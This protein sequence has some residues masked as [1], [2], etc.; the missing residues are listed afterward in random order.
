MLS[1]SSKLLLDEIIFAGY[2]PAMPKPKTEPGLPFSAKL[3]PH[4]MA[5]LLALRAHMEGRTGKPVSQSHVLRCALV[6]L[7]EAERDNG[8]VP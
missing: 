3:K 8:F 5:L 6:A 2:I 7:T 1:S 4:E